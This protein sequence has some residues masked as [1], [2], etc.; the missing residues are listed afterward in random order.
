V[1]AAQLSPLDTVKEY[2]RL[3]DSGDLDRAFTIFAPEASV[4]FGDLPVLS[5][6]DAIS[7]HIR[8]MVVPVARAISHEVV[9][10]Y[11][12]P[13]PGDRATVICE[14]VVTYSMLR[15]GNVIAHNAV[16]ISELAPDGK[17]VVQRN[18]GNLGPVI[19]D[20]RR[21]TES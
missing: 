16:T 5:G 21:H 17:I 12:V 9:R 11:T 10:D 6:R 8:G 19:D 2:Y 7:A 4:R 1:S 18:V 20:H 14:A 15:S 13:G 3:I